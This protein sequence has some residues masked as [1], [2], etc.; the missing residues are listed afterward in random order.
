MEQQRHMANLH[1]NGVA[2]Y[3]MHR[4][5]VGRTAQIQHSHARS[6]GEAKMSS[7]SCPVIGPDKSLMLNK[8][9]AG[10]LVHMI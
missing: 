10:G 4:Y 6:G 7:R 5:A 9:H 1:Q 3:K 8:M 2:R